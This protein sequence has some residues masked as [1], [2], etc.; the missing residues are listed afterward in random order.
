MDISPENLNVSEISKLRSSL[1]VPR[2]VVL[3]STVGQDGVYNVAPYAQFMAICSKP[4]TICFSVVRREGG[5]KKDTLVNIEL[6]REFVLNLVDEDMAEAM[7][8]TAATYPKGVSE[9]E[10]AGLTPIRSDVV[11]AP[12]VAEAPASMECKLKEILE[13]G[14]MPYSAS[15][16]VGEIA[17]FHVRDD[18]YRNGEVDEV[19]LR[20]VGRL[21]GDRY[22][23]IR[24]VFQ[25]KTPKV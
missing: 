6:S 3:V 25:M 4:P 15:L 7:N 9:F 8:K 12:R 13:Y 19:G 20:P 21:S 14:E 2:P 5:Q 1:I 16:I 18:L 17:R 10:M 22:C 11:K 23:R 24:D